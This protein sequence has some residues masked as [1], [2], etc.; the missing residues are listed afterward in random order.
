MTLGKMIAKSHLNKI[1]QLA[2]LGFVLALAVTARAATFAD[3]RTRVSQA[4]SVIQQLETPDYYT[5]NS[6]QA[7]ELVQNALARLR[8][9]LPASETVLFN[10]QTIDVDNQ[11]FHEALSEYER[12]RRTGQHNGD[13]IRHTRE[14]LRALLQRLDE[15]KPAASTDDKDANKARLAEILRRPEYDKSVAQQSA[16]ER[17]WEQFIRWLA[18]LFPKFKPI[19]P[20]TGRSLSNIAQ[21][22]VFGLSIALIAFLIWKFLP[23]YLRNRGKK[24]KKQKREPRIVLGER[25]EP[26]QTAADLLE[27]AEALAR[28]GDL[29]GAIRK[30]YIALL[31]ELGDRKVISLAQ[32]KTN[33][34]YLMAIRNRGSLYESLRRL[35]FS[36]ERHWYG[37]VPPAADDWNEFRVGVRTASG[38]DRNSESA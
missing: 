27:Q 13:L 22:I 19:Q 6:I 28:A 35:T 12:R 10:N 7:E 26:D 3:Y 1:F 31:C 8:Q 33:R 25:L 30:A 4:A 36:F 9:L 29:R 24:K 23:R 5:N 16:L 18:K 15:M 34:D 38:S 11:W 17:L 37:F 14:Q 20:G 32:H 2:A 21:I